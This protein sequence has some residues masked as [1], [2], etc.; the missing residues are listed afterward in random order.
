MATQTMKAHPHSMG[1]DTTM[2]SMTDM[3]IGHYGRFG[4]M[5]G[6]SFIAMYVLMYAMVNALPNV[7]NSVNQFYMAGLM[8][9]PMAIIE[10]LLMRSMYP[11]K[12][13]NGVIL[14]VSFL[15]LAFF[16][17]GIRNQIGVGDNQF[18]R[19]MIPHHAGAILMCN[20]ANIQDAELKGLCANIVKGQQAEVEQMKAILGRLNK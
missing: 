6:L 16:W 10:I 15:A 11:D 8:A 4:I 12:K 7:Y 14:I 9:A 13:L 19:S 18:V 3:K 1:S 2:K 5:V 20:E 17:T